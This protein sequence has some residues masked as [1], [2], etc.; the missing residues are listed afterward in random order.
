MV[1]RFGAL[2]MRERVLRAALVGGA[3]RADLAVRPGLPADPG[4][5]VEA[6]APIVIPRPPVPLRFV[7]PAHVLRDH[8][9]T[10]RGELTGKGLGARVSL[11]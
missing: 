9:V 6:V 4:G 2:A 3:E 7:A 10:C 8:H 1:V 5:R 11:W